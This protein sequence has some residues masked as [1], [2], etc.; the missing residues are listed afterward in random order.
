MCD[1]KKLQKLCRILISNLNKETVFIFAS[2]KLGDDA[3][4]RLL[5]ILKAWELSVEILSQIQDFLG[6]VQNG[7]FVHATLLDQFVHDG[8]VDEIFSLE[9]FANFQ[10]HIDRSDGQK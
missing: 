4:M 3:E 1:G 9:L 2:Q 7:V 10:S 6:N 5:E 8:G